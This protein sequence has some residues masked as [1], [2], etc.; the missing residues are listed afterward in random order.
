MLHGYAAGVFIDARTRFTSPGQILPAHALP[1]VYTAKQCT[2]SLGQN[3][4]NTTKCAY[5]HRMRARARARASVCV[6]VSVH[7]EKSLFEAKNLLRLYY[8]LL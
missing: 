5:T 7:N 8:I 6:R 3:Q 1:F 4:Q 2:L